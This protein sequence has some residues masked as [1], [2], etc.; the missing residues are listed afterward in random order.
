MR[1]WMLWLVVGGLLV[2]VGFPWQGVW[3]GKKPPRL[4]TR[5]VT[6]TRYTWW[7]VPWND[8]RDPQCEVQVYHPDYPT[9]VEIYRACGWEAYRA[10]RTTPPC[11]QALNGGD[12]SACTGYYLFFVR[13]ERVTHT[14]TRTFPPPTARLRLQGCTADL[15][16]YRCPQPVRLQIQGIEFF[17][18]AKIQYV[19]VR[20]PKDVDV[21]CYGEACLVTLPPTQRIRQ[22]TL[23][24]WAVSSLGDSTRH[25]TA[26]VRWVPTDAGEA[27]VVDIIAPQWADEGADVCEQVGRVFPPLQG[28]PEWARTPNDP[29]DLAT[30]KPYA[31]LAGRL[32]A[33][34][35]VDAHDCPGGGLSD[36]Q[37]NA[38][39]LARARLAVTLWQNRYDAGL[40]AAAR[41]EGV[42]AVL[43]K[44][45]IGRESQFWPS[46]YP[47]RYEVG[48]GQLSP[49][50][51]DTLLLWDPRFFQDL[52]RST[53][54]PSTCARGYAA[55]GKPWRE[56]LYGALWVQADL[57]CTDCPYGVDMTR[58]PQSV[59]LFARLMRAYCCQTYQ[60]VYNVS[61]SRQR[62]AMQ[63]TDLW[64]FALADYNG[65]D[66]LSRALG[67][68][69]RQKQP[70]NWE[71]VRKAFSPQCQSVRDYV[72]SVA[73]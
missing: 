35:V 23:Q 6:D 60:I 47:R 52:C 33:A 27:A 62:K 22:V 31:F 36:E 24:F 64:R 45:L 30:D 3:A 40:L 59:E 14:V 13:A 18:E 28:L 50:G 57:T 61:T 38:C 63:Y 53:L 48:L 11:P 32:I 72:E 58:V 69:I 51:M 20:A 10:W 73:P 39:G 67:R 26:K 41:R 19:R 43:F 25:Y 7:L 42:P 17:P 54:A 49:Q 44:R 46:V 68:T 65:P 56:M 71:H 37:A 34:G 12:V 8:S 21:A 9:A 55:L 1:R 2:V 66:C 16:H 70:L 15:P 4:L 5:E 29:T